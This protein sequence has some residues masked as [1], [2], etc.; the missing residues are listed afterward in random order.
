MKNILALPII[1]GIRRLAIFLTLACGVYI[2]FF[3]LYKSR[4]NP[5]YTSQVM[6]NAK[7]HNLISPEPEF[8]IKPY[9]ASDNQARDIFSLNT[10][11]ASNGV[12]ESTPKGQLPD[13]LKVVGILIGHPSQ[14]IIEDSAIHKTYFID[15][16]NPQAGFSILKVEKDQIIINYQGQNISV[17]VSKT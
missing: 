4:E 6:A 9:N 12:V 15:E 17:P 10:G 1:F 16:G 14:I 3:I 7:N 8:A 13:H 5:A 2:V 11:V